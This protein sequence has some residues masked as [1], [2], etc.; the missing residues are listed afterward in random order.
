MAQVNEDMAKCFYC[1]EIFEMLIIKH[2]VKTFHP[3]KP[4]IFKTIKNT[5]K[6][7][8]IYHLLNAIEEQ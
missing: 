8:P 2:H 5:I 6:K 3:S 7:E 4:I 1:N